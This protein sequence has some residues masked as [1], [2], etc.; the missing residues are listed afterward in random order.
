[1][2]VIP[3]YRHPVSP[4][5]FNR[6]VEYRGKSHS[7]V[8]SRRSEKR[9]KRNTHSSDTPSYSRS[10][11][12]I[13]WSHSPFDTEKTSIDF[14]ASPCTSEVGDRFSSLSNNKLLHSHDDS[15]LPKNS[16]SLESFAS[17]NS[18]SGKS[19]DHRRHKKSRCD[20][21][22]Q[23]VPPL[24][25]NHRDSERSSCNNSPPCK[26]K[27]FRDFRVSSNVSTIETSSISSGDF[28]DALYV[29]TDTWDPENESNKQIISPTDSIKRTPDYAQY[30]DELSPQESLPSV[31]IVADTSKLLDTESCSKENF[32]ES[33]LNLSGISAISSPVSD[34]TLPT[35]TNHVE[36]S[37]SNVSSITPELDK[38]SIKESASSNQ[39]RSGADNS[40]KQY[41]LKPPRKFE[42]QRNVPVTFPSKKEKKLLKV[43]VPKKQ[44]SKKDQKPK[45]VNRKR[46]RKRIPDIPLIEMDSL[47][48][49]KE[50]V[51]SQLVVDVITSSSSN[52]MPL[53]AT[54]TSNAAFSNMATLSL[55]QPDVL[56]HLSGFG[57]LSPTTDGCESVAP[58][59]LSS[60][61]TNLPSKNS[62]PLSPSNPTLRNKASLLLLDP[63]VLKHLSGFGHLSSASNRSESATPDALN[64]NTTDPSSEYAAT[65]TSVTSNLTLSNSKVTLSLLQ[66]DVLKQLSGL[67]RPS[68]DESANTS[69]LSSKDNCVSVRGSCVSTMDSSMDTSPTMKVSVAHCIHSVYSY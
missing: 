69:D 63:D 14:T 12:A 29:V 60:N 19:S 1:M 43:P 61:T 54:H 52:S 17:S 15:L 37:I 27:K 42:I 57:H 41:I 31:G 67:D 39:T 48:Y 46:Q 9:R 22:T 59:P 26:E 6:L 64:S 45:R 55:L 49:A 66:P 3:L 38:C 53:P 33:I 28:S 65:S 11:V 24:R 10:N 58:V 18:A 21:N 50:H 7:P 5:V 56:K 62:I 25:Q 2:Y 34:S 44:T 68:T 47:E 51:L 35:V 30:F 4:P 16:N 40:V 13:R 23:F 36:E 32:D 8:P 20:R